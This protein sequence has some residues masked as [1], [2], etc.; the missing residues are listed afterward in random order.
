GLCPAWK[1]GDISTNWICQEYISAC[2]MA[3]LNTAGIHIPIW[4][5][6]DNQTTKIGWGVDLTN[7]PYQEG[8]F[9]G[10]ILITG[11]YNHADYNAPVGF[12]CDGD[13]FA[14]GSSG[15]GAGRIGDS[16]TAAYSN[17]WSGNPLC[18][19]NCTNHYVS[20]I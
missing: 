10:N 9:F 6:A 5:D 7:Y 11:H 13:G 19:N 20:G 12:Y 15:V 16:A 1:S 3:H 8:T 4:L 14:S 2:V 18:K 17:P